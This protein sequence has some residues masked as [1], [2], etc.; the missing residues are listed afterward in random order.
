M[1][2][3]ADAFKRILEVFDR[4]EIPY[5]VGGSVASSVHGISRPTMDVDFI[6]AIRDDHIDEFVAEL[7]TDFYADA[8]M[9]RDSVRSGRP[10]NLIHFDSAF[11]YDVFPSAGDHYSETQLARRK[12]EKASAM[13]DEPIECAVSTAEDIILN[14]L[15]WYRAGGETSERQWNDLRGILKVSGAAIDLE[16]LR[17]WAPQ[18]GVQDLLN[19][20]LGE[21]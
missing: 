5:M 3:P 21:A 17:L 2:N 8:E 1:K 4:L 9:I 12:F 11:K 7:K 13:G 19:K 15:R 10:F 18:L 6:A 16:Y 20:L 14:K